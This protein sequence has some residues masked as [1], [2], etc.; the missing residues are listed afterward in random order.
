[1]LYIMQD[2]MGMC[3]YDRLFF[4]KGSLRLGPTERH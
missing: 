2:H 4:V 3:L 1:M